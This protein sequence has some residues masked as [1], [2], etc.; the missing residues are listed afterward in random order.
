MRFRARVTRG[1]SGRWRLCRRRGHLSGLRRRDDDA[2]VRGDGGGFDA[3]SG[4]SSGAGETDAASSCSPSDVLTFVQGPY[5]P[6]EPPSAA[7][8]DAD[9]AGIW[10][11]FY[12][13]CLGPNKTNQV[14]TAFKQD[15]ANAACAACVLTPDTA[16]QLGPILSFG[17][18]VGGNVAGCIELTTPGDPT[19]AR[20]VQA[21]SDC[22]TAACQANCPPVTD[23]PS[24]MARQECVAAADQG[25]CLMFVQ[26]T[27]ADCA[28]ADADSGLAAPCMNASFKDFYEEAVPLFCG[29]SAVDAGAG[30]AVDASASDAGVSDAGESDAGDAD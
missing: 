11:D 20:D 18:F 9:G 1:G 5:Q 4:S 13:A 23:A 2:D 12:D 29:Q 30:I 21:L 27:R 26:M 10:D 14:C 25:G 28:A 17:E 16:D 3:S 7:C 24:L 6:A 15:P 8:L 22:E 19:C